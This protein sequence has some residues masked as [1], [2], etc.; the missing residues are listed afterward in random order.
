MTDTTQ[1][2]GEGAKELRRLLRLTTARAFCQLV[3]ALSVLVLGWQV[4]TGRVVVTVM[5]NAEYVCPATEDQ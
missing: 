2:D 4:A 5:G 1:T 3:V